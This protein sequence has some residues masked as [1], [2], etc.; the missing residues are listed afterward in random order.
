VIDL[1][2]DPGFWLL[3][4]FGLVTSVHCVGMC[5]GLLWSQSG[6]GLRSSAEYNAGRVVS[7]TLFGA[8][9]G[10]LGQVVAPDLF[11]NTASVQDR[12]RI[13]LACHRSQKE[14][15]DVSHGMDAY[16]HEM[17]R[18]SVEV[19]RM[20]E[21]FTHAEGWRLHNML[22]FGPKDF[23]PLRDLL[24]GDCHASTAE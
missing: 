17:E 23:N 16:L 18:M 3:L 4:A 15:L 2:R 22:G 8:L 13:L 21:C 19:G 10:G 14:W 5:G 20:S 9:A 6:L 7:Y 1:G 12:Q 11:V 24:K